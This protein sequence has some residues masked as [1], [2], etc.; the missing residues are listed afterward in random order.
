MASLT[1]QNIYKSFGTVEVLKGTNSEAKPGEFIVLVGPSGCGKSTLLSMI[2]GLETVTS[3]EI[4]IGDRLVNS[5]AL[6][7]RCDIA[8]T[9]ALAVAI[10]FTRVA[11]G[12]IGVLVN[13]AANDDRRP[14][15][16]VTPD[17]WESSMAINLKPHFIAAQAVRPHMRALGGKSIVNF[18]SIARRHGA[19]TMSVY[20]T[21]KSAVLGLTCVLARGFGADNIRVNSIKP[22]AVITDRQRR[23]WYP[24][25]SDV[26]NMV[27]RQIIK[28]VLIGENIARVAFFLASDDSSMIT[29]QSIIVD[30]G[31]H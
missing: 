14:I 18:S 12:N 28:R 19:G 2:A 26:D 4:H 17:Y 16:D 25:Q 6:F 7:I 11:L 30:G 5:V 1:I 20:A 24:K 15:N 10:E 22:G 21:A 13:N 3:D 9:N 29:K 8:L 23:I 27:N 31:L